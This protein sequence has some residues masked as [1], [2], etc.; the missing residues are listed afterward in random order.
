MLV[1][2]FEGGRFFLVSESEVFPI[3]NFFDCKNS[4]KGSVFLVASGR[5]V[6]EF[7][8]EFFS[9]ENFVAMNGS[10]SKFVELNLSPLFY[11]CDDTSFVEAHP[12][13]AMQG[14]ERSVNVAMSFE[15]YA[16][17]HE[18]YPRS[19][20]RNNLYLL[21]RANRYYDR[22]SVS[23]RRFAWSIRKDK[24]LHSC[25]SLLKSKPNRIG[26]SKNMSRGYFIA[27]TIP[28]VGL[29]LAYHLGFSKVFLLGVDLNKKA[30]RFYE[31][32]DG[33]VQ[34][35]NI[36]IDYFKYIEPSFRFA[37]K[38]IF[39]DSFRVYNVSKNSR[40]PHDI[41]PKVDLEFVKSN[42]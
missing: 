9:K 33:K 42:L 27:R 36:D 28:Y 22:E 31:R 8:F 5:S 21:Y 41:V 10:I 37:K 20:F 3:N 6:E 38:Y 12:D 18:F 16:K 35:T 2:N 7:S 23:D 32:S 24:E 1:L 40:L 11:I 34:P 14:V 13:L 30:G 17:L 26:F 15:C 39:S 4:F 29:Q 25:F 19:L